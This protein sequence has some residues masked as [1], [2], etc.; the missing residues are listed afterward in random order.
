MKRSRD[1]REDRDGMKKYVEKE[2]QGNEND[3]GGRVIKVRRRMWNGGREMTKG[4]D[5]RKDS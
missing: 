3:K 2:M 4:E 1:C 5:V